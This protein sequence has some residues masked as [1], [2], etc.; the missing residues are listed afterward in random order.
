MMVYHDLM[1]LFVVVPAVSDSIHSRQGGLIALM[2]TVMPGVHA[3]RQT[4]RQTD[5]R[6]TVTS[7]SLP[8]CHPKSCRVVYKTGCSIS[9]KMWCLHN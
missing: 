5:E 8:T 6:V 9:C 4:D 3:D 7:E 2:T 1:F